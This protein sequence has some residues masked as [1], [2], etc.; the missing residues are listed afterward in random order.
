MKKQELIKL[1]LTY[2]EDYLSTLKIEELTKRIRQ[3]KN[4][5][6]IFN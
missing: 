3:A 4:N 5:E 6:L 2:Y 1:L